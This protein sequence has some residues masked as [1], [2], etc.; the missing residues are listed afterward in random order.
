[1]ER[2]EKHRQLVSVWTNIRPTSHRHTE[3]GTAE[4]NGRGNIV[5]WSSVWTNIRPTP[6]RHTG[7][8]TAEWNGQRNIV[9]RSV[10]EPID[11]VQHLVSLGQ[12][13]QS[14]TDGYTAPANREWTNTS[15]FSRLCLSITCKRLQDTTISLSI[16]FQRNVPL[17][18]PSH[19]V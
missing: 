13:L 11:H 10:Y 2:T 17:A 15:S 1:M 18:A 6:H 12:V 14:G 19:L 7:T 8:G 4:W 3:T 16:M 9:S 5:S